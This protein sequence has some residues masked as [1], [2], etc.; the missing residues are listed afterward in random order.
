MCYNLTVINLNH[1]MIHRYTSRLATVGTAVALFLTLIPS[2]LAAGWVPITS[3]GTS[4]DLLAVDCVSSKICTAVGVSGAI[5]RSTDKK[6][7]SAVTSPVSTDLNAIDFHSTT[8]IAVGSNGV[9]LRSTDSG[10]TWTQVGSGVT[11]EYLYAV[12]MVSASTGWAAGEDGKLLKTTDAGV[13]WSVVATAPMVDYRSLDATSTTHVWAGG[14][15]GLLYK[16][17]DG[18]TSWTAQTS[19]VSGI[20]AVIDMYSSNVGYFG[21]ENRAFARTANGGTLWTSITLTDF[22]TTETVTGLQFYTSTHGTVVGSSGKITAL[23]SGGSTQS[24]TTSA[25][26]LFGL[27][28]VAAGAQV[29]V[30][31][32]GVITIIDNYGPNA[33]TNFTTTSI[34]NDTTPTFTWTAAT[35]DESA[36]MSYWL[37][38]NGAAA[39]NVGLSTSH[40]VTSVISAGVHTAVIY[41]VDGGANIG[42][43]STTLTFTID[44][45]NPTVGSVSPTTAIVGTATQFVVIASDT[46]GVSSCTLYLNSV[47]TGAMTY[48]ATGATYYRSH[49]FST[50]GTYSAYASCTDTVGNSVAGATGSVT[51]STAATTATTTT[52]TD[53]TAPTVGSITPTS[54]TQNVATTIYATYSDS[55]GVT[56]CVLYVDGAS[57]GAMSLSGGR[58][59]LSR[60]PSSAG[61]YSAHIKCYDAAGNVGTGATTTITVS[62]ATT[63]ATTTQVDSDSLIK[64]ACADGADVND[65][66]RA[67]Y[68]YDGKRHAFPN[69]KVFYSWYENFDNVIIVTDDFMSSITLGFNITYRPGSTMVKFQSLNTVYCVD[70][71]GVLR[72]ITSE[73]VASSIFGSDWNT[74]VDDISDAFYGN[75]TFGDVI[76]N[77]SD[78]DPTAVYNATTTIA[79]D[80]KR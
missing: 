14:K 63:T 49:T 44:T 2:A 58:A 75:Y 17:T 66:C 7:W 32:G 15:S 46:N 12:K 42:S 23:S 76:D 50:A 61:S 67:V 47:S 30:G 52:T 70:K 56:S 57:H 62:V 39:V 53:T 29:A 11:T 9:L 37:S 79:A 45:T 1:P 43:N 35:D 68:Y 13:N 5:V 36:I 41:A 77:T 71:G 25:T 31:S 3:S 60:T 72:G 24:S 20:I 19:G 65:P 38:I 55:F 54:V 6:T 28:V 22:G 21:G 64:M 27:S 33:P 34:S 8:G 73:D 78:F 18:G 48:D 80:L 40:T 69:E 10:S 16:S 4:S 59:S 51:V 74:Q 26:G